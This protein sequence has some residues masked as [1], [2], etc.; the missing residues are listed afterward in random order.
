MKA[1]PY[2]QLPLIEH[3]GNFIEFR[4]NESE[5]LQL[6]LS[7]DSLGNSDSMSIVNLPPR[8]YSDTIDGKNEAKQNGTFQRDF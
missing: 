2:I 4:I 8:V 3:G 7:K 6:R 1:V 5:I